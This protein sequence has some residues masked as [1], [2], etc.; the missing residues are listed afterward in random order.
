M[1]PAENDNLQP[2]ALQ[3]L[4]GFVRA[5]L[6]QDSSDPVRWLFEAFESTA[7]LAERFAENSGMLFD[8]EEIALLP[9]RVRSPLLAPRE[10]VNPSTL[11]AKIRAARATS[12]ADQSKSIA[13][14]VADEF[15]EESWRVVVGAREEPKLRLALVAGLNHWILGGAWY[16]SAQHCYRANHEIKFSARTRALLRP[17]LRADDLARLHRRM[18]EDAFPDE[19]LAMSESPLL[20]R[21][22]WEEMFLSWLG[23][24]VDLDDDWYWLKTVGGLGSPTRDDE[25]SG[26]PTD[27]YAMAREMIR[28]AASLYRLRGTPLGLELMI[29]DLCGCRARIVERAWPRALQIGVTSSVG[30]DCLFVEPPSLDDQ[31]TVLLSEEPDG[32]AA[33]DLFAGSDSPFSLGD[34]SNS[35]SLASRLKSSA[36]AVSLYLRDRLKASTQTL[37]KDWEPSVAPSVRLLQSIVEDLNSIREGDSIWDEARFASVRLRPET[38]RLLQSNP[39]GG[40]RCRLNRLLLEDAYPLELSRNRGARVRSELDGGESGLLI[41]WILDTEP[42]PGPEVKESASANPRGAGRARLD[43]LRSLVDRERPAHTRV[44]LAIDALV[45]EEGWEEPGPFVVEVRSTIGK[46]WID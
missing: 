39:T 42:S 35:V 12:V 33:W 11:A 29:R 16:S 2:E 6:A 24:W 8:P 9:G 36:G 34:F 43:R 20:E 32:D 3:Y 18:L 13:V 7:N 19:I 44:F 40:E 41:E 4:P 26:R 5:D 37:L 25:G 17:D 27:H 21:D 15:P 38:R 14:A 30:F 23:S 45:S 22:K 31:F 10:L 1:K 46:F 28:R